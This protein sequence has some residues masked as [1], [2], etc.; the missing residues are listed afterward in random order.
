MLRFET[1]NFWCGR[2]FEID[3]WLN[4]LK[5]AVNVEGYVMEQD[6]GEI[7]ITVSTF[8]TDGKN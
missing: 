4:S 1:K 8:T 2:A 7:T 5:G 3:N 6:S